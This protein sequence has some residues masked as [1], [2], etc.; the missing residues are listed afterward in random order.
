MPQESWTTTEAPKKKRPMGLKARAA[1]K[2]QKN[3]QVANGTTTEVGISDFDEANMATIMLKGTTGENG[4]ATEI[5]ELEGIF[6]SAMGELGGAADGES[7]TERAVTLLRGTIHECDRILRIHHHHHEG[8][9]AD[10]TPLEPRFYYIY[11][12]A[13][14]SITELSE[15]PSA[16]RKEYLELAYERL[17]QARAAMLGTEPF[18]W[19][20]HVGMAKA[21]LE[22]LVEGQTRNEDCSDDG[23]LESLDC[24]LAALEHDPD[25]S[26][27]AESLATVDL[28]LSLADSRSL[29]PALNSRLV[30]WGETKLRAM[31][32]GAKESDSDARY[33]LARAL[34]HQASEL[35]DA[36]E[37]EDDEEIPEK[38]KIVELLSKAS[39]LLE[40]GSTSDALLLRGE[41][42]LNL[43]NVQDDDSDQE[44]FYELA[45]DTF[46][47]AQKVGDIPD[48]FVQLIN[49]FEQDGD[50]SDSN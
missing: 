16:D 42:I 11:G 26:T 25:T 20:V 1:K 44:K 41:V 12:T 8:E 38:Q 10:K 3:D 22:L 33:L 9:Q 23:P 18:A 45:V 31:L 35:L 14:Y 37:G 7:T 49:D 46:K 28:V 47:R 29:P 19:R 17:G 30:A 43:G 40:D 13:L 48:Q 2:K 15:E 21:A 6:D 5:D 27:H 32:K 34:W 39:E 4:E 36:E 50:E 24:A